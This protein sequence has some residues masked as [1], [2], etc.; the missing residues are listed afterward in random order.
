MRDF[1]TWGDLLFQEDAV[2]A[3]KMVMDE[4]RACKK[5][6][7]AVLLIFD[8]QGKVADQK[9]SDILSDALPIAEVPLLF[10]PRPLLRIAFVSLC[11]PRL[12]S[13]LFPVGA[14]SA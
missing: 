7:V 2:E 14:F 13:C 3:H 10:V 12:T 6:D 4:L 9:G 8:E 1:K 11:T 5:E